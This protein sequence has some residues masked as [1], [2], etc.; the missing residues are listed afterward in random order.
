MGQLTPEELAELETSEAQQPELTPQQF[1]QERQRVALEG[2]KR[3]TPTL[4]RTALNVAATGAMALPGVGPLAASGIAAG[5]TTLSQMLGLE[6][7]DVGAIALSGSLPLLAPTVIGGVK[8]SVKGLLELINPSAV[9][10]AGAE[11]AATKMGFKAESIERVFTTPASQA[12]YKQAKAVGN[13]YAPQLVS[14]LDDAA[15]ALSKMGNPPY[16]AMSYLRNISRK[17]NK[18]GF[19]DYADV[20][21]EMQMLNKKASGA[22]KSGDHITGQALKDARMTLIDATDLISPQLKKANNLFLREEASKDVLEAFRRENPIQAL[23]KLFETDKLVQKAFPDKPTVKALYD[24]AE[25]IAG[26]TT[27]PAGLAGRMFQATVA[28]IARG[29]DKP[30]ARAFMRQLM[31]PTGKLTPAGFATLAQFMRAYNVDE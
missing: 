23:E 20:M 8:G 15:D 18:S 6:P 3:N 30:P 22:F 24:V 11:L 19:V 21:N 17:W 5:G 9:R 31:Q 27:S 1:T 29:L 2:I 26:I 10:R 7:K 12:A 4:A 13:V 25:S 16:A 14:T 28:P